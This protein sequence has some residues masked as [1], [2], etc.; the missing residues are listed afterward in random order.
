[1]LGWEQH[2]GT[3]VP[4]LAGQQLLRQRQWQSP[5][6]LAARRGPGHRT[7]S[8]WGPHQICALRSSPRAP[9]E[10]RGCQTM[11]H[12]NPTSLPRDVRSENPSCFDTNSL[13]ADQSGGK[14]RAWPPTAAAVASGQFQQRLGC[15][16]PGQRGR[17]RGQPLQL[18]IFWW[19]LAA[20]R[21]LLSTGAMLC[22]QRFSSAAGLD[23]GTRGRF[24]HLAAC[25]GLLAL[26]RDGTCPGAAATSSCSPRSSP[27]V[28]PGQGDKGGC[29]SVPLAPWGAA[30]LSLTF[31]GSPERLWPCPE[32]GDGGTRT[33]GDFCVSGDFW[34]WKPARVPLGRCG[35]PCGVA[36]PSRA[37]GKGAEGTEMGTVTGG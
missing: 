12:N 1:M 37:G 10:V 6:A 26:L 4:G 3:A 35:A 33:S 14:N 18:P 2:L 23:A 28:L 29:C 5:A 11:A 17:Q 24:L 36:A 34:G 19:F 9:G 8:H 31:G 32:P 7:P 25:L 22:S 21:V 15:L 20:A 27:R 13:R 16:H 30:E